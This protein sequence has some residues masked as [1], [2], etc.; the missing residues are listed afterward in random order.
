MKTLTEYITG[1]GAIGF[2][3]KACQKKDKAGKYFTVIHYKDKDDEF[4][5]IEPAT[6][7]LFFDDKGQACKYR[8]NKDQVFVR[9]FTPT[10]GPN[11]GKPI[12]YVCQAV[13]LTA[14]DW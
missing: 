1:L 14:N 10:E 13:M 11:A 2:E 12:P 8:G 9:E 5:A 7:L 6:A 4:A 3:V